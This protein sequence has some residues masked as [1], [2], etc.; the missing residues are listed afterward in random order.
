MYLSVCREH[1]GVQAEWDDQRHGLDARP[2]M[3]PGQAGVYITKKYLQR[4]RG[5]GILASEEKGIK[6]FEEEKNQKGYR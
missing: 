2:N 6:S 3:Q 4:G 5:G 1:G